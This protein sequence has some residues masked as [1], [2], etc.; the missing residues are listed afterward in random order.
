MFTPD[1]SG[2]RQCRQRARRVFPFRLVDCA[3]FAAV[4]VEALPAL[5][6][7]LQVGTVAGVLV[8]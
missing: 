7:S 3:R 8:Q 5:P 1:H 2:F 4:Q 6:H